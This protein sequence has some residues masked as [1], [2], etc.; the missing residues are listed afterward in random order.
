VSAD[1]QNYQGRLESIPASEKEYMELMHERDL[2]KQ[3]YDDMESKRNRSALSVDMERRKQ[4]ETLEV[5]DSASLPAAPTAPKRAMIVPAG[6][7]I[8]LILG[9]LLVGIREVKDTSLKNLKDARLYTQLSILGSIQ[10][11]ENDLVVQRRRQLMLVGWAT[12]T[13]VGLAIM[14][15]SIAH[16]YLNLNKA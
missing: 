15:F 5:L 1:L 8:G 3:H 13:V 9:I 4:G 6:A 11:L 14:G 16:Y 7:G 12:A 10:L 2:A